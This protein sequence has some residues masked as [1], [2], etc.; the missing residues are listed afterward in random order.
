MTVTTYEE[1]VPRAE[2]EYV[3]FDRREDCFTEIGKF[4]TKDKKLSV[5]S[6]IWLD[7]YQI[8]LHSLFL[9][10]AS[11]EEMRAI[12]GFDHDFMI[13]RSDKLCSVLAE[14]QPDLST[15]SSK[16]QKEL[17]ESWSMTGA[18]AVDESEIE[19]FMPLI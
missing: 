10:Y 4:T 16:S 13:I 12:T 17:L 8:L 7:D 1:Y 14:V 18:T 5:T 3:I 6:P 15:P 9:M 19:P 2:H 11:R